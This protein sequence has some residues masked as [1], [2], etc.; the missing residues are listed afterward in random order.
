MEPNLPKNIRDTLREKVLNDRHS[1]YSTIQELSTLLEEKH[2]YRYDISNLKITCREYQSVPLFIEDNTV[3]IA[4]SLNVTDDALEFWKLRFKNLNIKLIYVTDRDM[5]YLLRH[6]FKDGDT[7]NAT[8]LFHNLNPKR[9]AKELTFSDK[10][11]IT[12][13]LFPILVVFAYSIWYKD[14]AALTVVLS[15]VFT[16]TFLVK[17]FL[18]LFSFKRPQKYDRSHNDDIEYP[19][20]SILVPLYKEV[21]II[22]HLL[23]SLTSLDYPK[24]KLDIK[25][26][27]EEEDTETINFAKS[28]GFPDYFDFVV[29]PNK[30]PRTKP[31]ACNYALPYCKGEYVVIYD[32]ED[33]PEPDQ[34]KKVVETFQNSPDNVA[35]IQAALNW[36]NRGETKILWIPLWFS[37][38][39]MQ[40]FKF[41]LPGLQNISS[42]IPLGGT[43]NHFKRAVL[44][45]LCGWDSFNV[46]EDA[47]LG[48]RLFEED[49]KTRMVDSTTW[50]ESPTRIMP[51]I[52]Q[53]S[54]WIKGHM[55]TVA[56]YMRRSENSSK[57]SLWERFLFLT[58]LAL[59]IVSFIFTLPAIVFATWWISTES[60]GQFLDSSIVF[61]YMV[62]MIPN[63][64]G[65]LLNL[66]CCIVDKEYR[67]IPFTVFLPIYWLLHGAA[68]LLA[69][70]EFYVTPHSWR[71]TE[72][73]K[74]IT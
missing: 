36:Y 7:E 44:L 39:Y 3:R 56:V 52:K 34:L 61:F 27:F 67:L 28:A 25:L 23:K 38:E 29:A 48:V 57:L 47:E 13:L 17:L 12:L 70:Y 18:T 21:D 2:D 64:A 65:I 55:V 73:G 45:K 10:F 53:R 31:R 16:T 11:T 49:Y 63:I 60:L 6:I 66:V 24:D 74:L 51:W 30:Y 46:T 54:R 19:M 58:F 62:I 26:I 42:P 9:S 20:Y 50:E 5:N 43:S 14:I 15:A 4:V 72:H 40:W 22:P 33:R 35:C 59:P 69:L 71:K 32:A 8:N 1:S 37:I 68:S 41:L